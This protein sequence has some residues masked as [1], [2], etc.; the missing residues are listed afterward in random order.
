METEV[1][2]NTW[3]LYFWKCG[4]YIIGIVQNDFRQYTTKRFNFHALTLTFHFIVSKDFFFKCGP[5]KKSLLNL[6]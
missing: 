1:S 3:Y 4:V 2:L 5:F 6:L